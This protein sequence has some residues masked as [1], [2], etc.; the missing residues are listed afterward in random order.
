VDHRGLRSVDDGVARNERWRQLLV[1]LAVAVVV[2]ALG[3]V[4]FA[5][6]WEAIGRL[7][8]VINGNGCRPPRRWLAL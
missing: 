2:A 8:S 7:A 1:G 5:S 6:G 4:W 3:W